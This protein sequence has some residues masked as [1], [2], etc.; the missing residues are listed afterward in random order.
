MVNVRAWVVEHVRAQRLGAGL[1][2]SLVPRRV[3]QPDVDGHH[4]HL[5]QPADQLGERRGGAHERQVRARSRGVV[6]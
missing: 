4:A 2:R 3:G 5:E 1:A 6:E